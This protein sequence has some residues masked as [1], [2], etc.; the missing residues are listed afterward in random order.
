ME[1]PVKEVTKGNKTLKIFADDMADDP[2]S[3]DNLS[4][5]LCYHS[6][7]NLGDKH[8]Y[9][10]RDYNSWD[11]MKQAILKKERTNNGGVAVI[12]PLYLYDHSG[13]T[14][15]TTPFGCRW[16]SGQVGFVIV[17]RKAI[18]ENWGVKKAT[19]KLIEQ[20]EKL[21]I[22]E[23]ETYDQFISGD[24]YRFI[25]EVDGEVKD[26]CGG[27]YGSKYKENGILD[28]I[29]DNELKELLLK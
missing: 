14:M 3:W 20:A 19:K 27:F 17:T 1:T 9:K 29:E 2:R 25:V 10:S 28:H 18:R 7:Y 6:R 11:E 5:M 13:I 16:D 21:A 4:K 24:V 12:L 23:V 22:G 15:K 8:D 26:S